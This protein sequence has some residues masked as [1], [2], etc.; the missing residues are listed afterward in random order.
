MRNGQTLGLVWR[1]SCS[2]QTPESL[3]YTLAVDF[4]VGNGQ[5]TRCTFDVAFSM[6][7]VWVI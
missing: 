7:T 2:G 6:G 5:T 3:E 4:V 1:G